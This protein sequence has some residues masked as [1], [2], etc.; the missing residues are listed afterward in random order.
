MEVYMIRRAKLAVI[1]PLGF[2]LLLGYS[3]NLQAQTE[4]KMSVKDLPAA[5]KNSFEKSYPNAK[6]KGVSKEEENGKTY[7]E[8]ESVDGKM[9]R[10]LLYTPEGVAY[11]IE[12]TI[13]AKALP[14]TVTDA[15]K[16]EFTKYTVSKAEKT[17]K[18]TSI[19]YDVA[20]KSGKKT[21]EVSIDPAGKVLSKKEMKAEKEKGEKEEDEDK[22]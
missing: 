18:G 11:E 12:E 13:A 15:L 14:Q 22:D 7:Y 8:V 9:N 4:K 17:T 2:A 6:I 16:K 5:V 21:Y 19:Q 1:V 20:V 3:T 10:D